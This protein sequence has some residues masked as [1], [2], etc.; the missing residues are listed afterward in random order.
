VSEPK[1]AAIEAA[2]GKTPM[3]EWVQAAIDVYLSPPAVPVAAPARDFARERNAS[4]LSVY[5]NPDLSEPSESVYGND[6]PDGYVSEA[7]EEAP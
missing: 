4:L 3:S 2:R 5:G 6:E 7:F 1:F